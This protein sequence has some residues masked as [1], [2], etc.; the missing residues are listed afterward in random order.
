MTESED[1]PRAAAGVAAEPPIP[2]PSEPAADGPGGDAPAAAAERGDAPAADE[3][4]AGA[5]GPRGTRRAP[6]G[7]FAIALAAL[8]TAIAGSLWWQYRQ[9]YVAL[10]DADAATARVLDDVR[11][12]IVRIDE[13]ID[14]LS[15]ELQANRARMTAI[16]DRVDALPTRLSALEQRIAAVRGGTLE[17]RAEWQRAEAEY[18]LALANSELLLAGR[19]E[20]A[21][22]ALERADR[23]LAEIGD[24][25]FAPVRAAI[26]EELIA[27]RSVEL[28][29]IDGLALSLAR[30]E[31]RIAGLPLGPARGSAPR[32]AVAA[33]EPGFGRLWQSVKRAL[34]GIVRVERSSAPLER[35]LSADE[36]V[37]LREHVELE[38]KLARLAALA[39]QPEAF[40]VSLDAAIAALRREFDAAAAEIEGAVALLESMRA[41]DIAPAKP[42][43]SGSLRRLRATTPGDD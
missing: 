5:H 35:R 1:R 14:A 4:P 36:R 3:R 41:L 12:G 21:M 23:A 13:R 17:A 27:L 22:A 10:D 30:L 26:A 43:I 38:L 24:P 20:S 32:E 33:A 28:P 29:D 16:D 15:A 2:A 39:G 34:A 40:R 8:A 37:L 19:W 18:H 11:A 6:A 9:F 25:S 31:E 42:D 7:L